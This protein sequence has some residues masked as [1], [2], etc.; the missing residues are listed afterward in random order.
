MLRTLRFQI[1][2]SI[3]IVFLML[4]SP[5]WLFADIEW[6]I[7]DIILGGDVQWQANCSLNKLKFCPAD[8]VEFNAN[9]NLPSESIKTNKQ[10][11]KGVRLVLVTERLFDKNGHPRLIDNN[12]MSTVLTPT[13]MPI[14]HSLFSGTYCGN[15]CRGILG[16]CKDR[17]EMS[18]FIESKDIDFE[19]R[20][21]NI[22]FSVSNKLPSDLPEGYYR[23]NV[24]FL[25]VFDKD[26]QEHIVRLALMSTLRLD[27]STYEIQPFHKTLPLLR[28]NYVSP[29]F[30]VGNPKTPKMI[31]ALFTDTIQ[32]GTQGIIAAEDK[33][34]FK[35]SPRH[36]VPDK[37]IIPPGRKLLVEPDFPSMFLDK[38]KVSFT[39]DILPFCTPID[40]DYGSGK[41]SVKITLPD[42]SKKNLGTSK[43]SEK[44][45]LGAGTGTK[46]HLFEFNKYGKYTINM[47]GWIKDIWG[48]RYEGGGTYIFWVAYRLGF[49][50]SVKPGSPFEAGSYYPTSVFVHPPLPANVSIDVEEYIYSQKDNVKKWHVDGKASRFG[51]FYSKDKIYFE[52]PGEYIAW[53]QAEYQDPMGR[54]WMGNQ[55]GSCVIAPKDSPLIVH[56][57]KYAKDMNIPMARYNLHDEGG[58][59]TI[60]DRLDYPTCTNLKAPFYSGDVMYIA[61]VNNGANAIDQI[62]TASLEGNFVETQSM[63]QPYNFPETITE[64]AYFYFSAIRPGIMARTLIAD[65]GANFGCSAWPT[66]PAFNAFGN[67]YN[68]TLAGDYPEDIYRFFGGFVYHS[69]DRKEPY[70]G[71]YAS[72]AMVIPKGSYANR[73]VAPL[74]EPLIEVNGREFYIFEAGAPTQGVIYEVGQPL[75]IGGFVF[76]AISD[77]NCTKEIVFPDG[78]SVLSK[79]SSNKIGLLKMSPNVVMADIPGVYTI[80]EHCWKDD[81]T[82]DVLGTTDGS[83]H[84][85]VDDKS[86]KKYFQVRTDQMPC[87]DALKGLLIEAIISEEVTNPRITYSIVMPGNVMD[88][89]VL[90]LKD[91]KGKYRF[92]PSEFNAQF[93]NYDFGVLNYKQFGDKGSFSPPFNNDFNPSETELIDLVMMTFF[94]EAIN[95]K[96]GKPVYDVATVMLRGN[97]VFMTEYNQ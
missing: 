74:T 68:V 23:F 38:A 52:K 10:F 56:G 49:A 7:S 67:Q 69:K 32:M 92:R 25:G 3:L 37:F 6:E 46:K 28:K 27:P 41:F 17:L 89:G 70:Y 48:N 77:I 4:G 93:P 35:I 36:S 72:M 97:R 19:K 95:K 9:L 24:E 90:A 30:R 88:E 31:W 81:K 1:S 80:K 12:Y 79:G 15:N 47:K 42:G 53:V 26:G 78:K 54:L 66:S 59:S 76:P 2:F 55:V 5:N 65:P 34:F 45:K 73:V 62:L 16:G 20:E 82:G 87:F 85:Y 61:G 58:S 8:I 83:Y 39:E 40:L 11:F 51:Y 50:T 60:P 57:Q 43:F 44:R 63:Y 75:G 33:V 96:T 18:T 29:V 86:T 22:D 21:L 91:Y 94:L 84:I 13:G 64:H 71:I 14:E